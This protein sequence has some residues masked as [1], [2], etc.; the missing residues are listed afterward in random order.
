MPSDP[1]KQIKQHI[2]LTGEGLRE[3][4]RAT[5][6]DVFFTS[7]L[8][9]SPVQSQPLLGHLMAKERTFLSVALS[10]KTS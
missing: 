6:H 9:S 8:R 2:W 10:G 1:E 5:L 4:S 3:Y 7:L